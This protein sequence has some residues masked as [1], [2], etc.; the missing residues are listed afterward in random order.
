MT[1]SLRTEAVCSF[2]QAASAAAQQNS[3]ATA[4]KDKWLEALTDG[5]ETDGFAFL[6]MVPLSRGP[7]ADGDTAR[8]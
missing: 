7:H 1:G 8:I 6:L 2:W 5:G 4:W 3:A